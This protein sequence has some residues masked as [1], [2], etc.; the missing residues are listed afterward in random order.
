MR[1]MVQPVVAAFLL[2]LG[3]STGA[4][5]AAPA[6]PLPPGV[7][8]LP[9][10]A[11]FVRD[12][13]ELRQ[14]LASATPLDIVL[15][16][17]VYRSDGPFIVVCGHRLY[18][19]HLGRAVLAAGISMGSDDCAIGGRVQGIAFDVQQAGA[20]SSGAAV[21]VWGSGRG[22]VLADL[23]IDGHRVLDAGII[24][25]Q[26]E[27][28]KIQRVLARNF[29]SW[30]ILV[31]ANEFDLAVVEP[32][33]LEDL[34]VANVSRPSPGASDGTAEA[35]IWVGNTAAGARFRVRN[36]AWMGVWTGTAARNVH[37]S[38]VDI[39]GI[40]S[41]QRTSV[42]L[43]LEHFTTDSVFER[44][45]IGPDVTIGVECE[46]ADPAWNSRPGCDGIVIQDSLIQTRCVGIYFDDG[47]R[48]ATVRRTAFV[49]QQRAAIA[50]FNKKFNL[51]YD[52]SGN[53]YSG[54][55][56]GARIV[57]DENNPC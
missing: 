40:G 49:D 11:V 13:A 7:Y 8:P 27:G 14:A 10:R 20:T 51:L 3:G 38:D 34:D 44:F 19:E 15:R 29:L 23:T 37:L 1:F 6:A 22:T 50:T 56:R 21:E 54:M 4:A 31:D 24:A 28:L 9:A 45:R 32:A 2:L 48:N 47:T 16:D 25:R 39:D 46:W 33:V 53:D 26:P 17:G 42:G 30:G 57:L 18:A 36:C 5:I 43:Y 12:S 52:T 35:C 55:K 41:P